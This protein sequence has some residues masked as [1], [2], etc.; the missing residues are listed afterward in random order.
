M[1]GELLPLEKVHIWLPKRCR[2][3]AVLEKGLFMKKMKPE[4]H[5]EQAACNAYAAI[6]DCEYR[7]DGNRGATTLGGPIGSVLTISSF[8]DDH[9]TLRRML[10]GLTRIA[11]QARSC[12]QALEY[13]SAEDVSVLICER[14][15]LDGNWKDILS[16]VVT[17][18]PPPALIVACRHADEH[19]WAEVLN[20]GAYDVLTKPF[21]AKEVLWIV[22]HACCRL[23]VPTRNA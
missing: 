9:I 23:R 17:K 15:L 10:H 4:F 21:N 13:L 2:E 3:C 6:D 8:D 7:K 20:L 14:N 16:A 22:H 11:L 1:D 5:P 12:R 19:L 18:N